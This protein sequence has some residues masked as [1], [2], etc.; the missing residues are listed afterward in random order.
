MQIAGHLGRRTRSL[1]KKF[2]SKILNERDYLVYVGVV[3]KIILKLIF[4]YIG[5][6]GVD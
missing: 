5:H 3:G 2:Q 6:E 1:H 4:E